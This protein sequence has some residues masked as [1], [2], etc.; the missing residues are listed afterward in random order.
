MKTAIAILAFSTAVLAQTTVGAPLPP[1]NPGTLNGQVTYT[2]E[3]RPSAP[4]LA[5]V[6]TGTGNMTN[7]A[8]SCVVTNITN[9]GET[10]ASAFS[11]AVTVDGTHKQLTVSRS[12]GTDGVTTGANVY[13]TKAGVDPTVASNYFL[14]ATSPVI[15]DNTSTS[16]TLNI[17]DGSFLTTLA[18]TYNFSGG[19]VKI[20]GTTVAHY[21]LADGLAASLFLL[22]GNPSASYLWC[23][24]NNSYN[25][26]DTLSGLCTYVDTSNNANFILANKTGTTGPYLYFNVD[27]TMLLGGDTVE[28]QT[29]S[30]GAGVF[31]SGTYKTKTNCAS[32]G[33]TC[34]AAAAGAVTIA[35]AATTVTVATTA[36][37]STSRIFIQENSTLGGELSVTCNTTIARTYA[38]TTVTNNTSFV[39]TASA[40]PVTNPACLQYWIVN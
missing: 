1:T 10:D 36:V 30:G 20:N 15:A 4:V 8:H 38:V 37:H 21:D 13:C 23:F 40:A 5:L 2:I 14:V 28:A 12:I 31:I 6:A 7:G 3:T 29:T 19:T 25:T 24:S 32:S 34:S 39:I 16:Y 9:N 17:A 33:G 27:N 22:R 11:N 18:P 26:N 35:A